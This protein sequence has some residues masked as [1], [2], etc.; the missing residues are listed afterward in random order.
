MI[1]WPQTVAL[2]TALVQFSTSSA[3]AL[4]PTFA[5]NFTNQTFETHYTSQNWSRTYTSSSRA[6][7]SWDLNPFPTIIDLATSEDDEQILQTRNRQTSTTVTG[8]RPA[9]FTTSTESSQKIWSSSM[10]SSSVV[11]YSTETITTTLFFL[12]D[13]SLIVTE[14]S[15]TT[16]AQT[17]YDVGS[18]AENT[19][20]QTGG[21][22]IEFPE[23][24]ATAS[25]NLS[26]QATQTAGF[27]TTTRF[28]ASANT[29]TKVASAVSSIASSTN[30]AI[31]TS[32]T[33]SASTTQTTSIVSRVTFAVLPQETVTTS[34]ITANTTVATF[35]ATLVASDTVENPV[36]T[37]VYFAATTKATGLTAG[38]I[39]Y[40]SLCPT[41]SSVIRLANGPKQVTTAS[42]AGADSAFGYFQSLTYIEPAN[43][44][45]NS[46]MPDAATSPRT[47]YGPAGRKIGESLGAAFSFVGFTQTFY[48]FGAEAAFGRQSNNSADVPDFGQGPESAG[49]V[50]TLLPESHT[51]AT[52]ST[53]VTVIIGNAQYNE[54]R[55]CRSC[56]QGNSS[57]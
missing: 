35:Q 42:G 54:T 38:G 57:T 53:S 41:T 51:F 36:T 18:A 44:A 9:I 14:Q 8:E 31:T 43:A 26:A 46:A 34:W 25:A 6:G 16:N 3:S 50:V 10:S 7:S 11:F 24:I 1:Q 39:Q 13:Q 28:T 30:E 37:T 52:S 33:Y 17:E 12:G 20:F 4:A 22:Q 29:Q 49:T 23:V 27:A 15:V 21:V 19:I 5:T 40:Q 56:I 55:V 45:I 2:Q 48:A 32:F 47:V